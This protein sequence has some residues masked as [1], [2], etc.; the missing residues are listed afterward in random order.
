MSC[1]PVLPTRLNP[2]PVGA[3]V[4]DRLGA[5]ENAK[6]APSRRS[7]R[8]RGRRNGSQTAHGV[9][10][11]RRAAFPGC[12]FGGLSSPPDQLGAGK[13]PEPAGRKACPTG[14]R[15]MERRCNNGGAAP[16][17]NPR[18][19]RASR[20]EGEAESQVGA[21]F[22]ASEEAGGL[23]SFRPVAPMACASLCVYGHV[24]LGRFAAA[25]EKRA[26]AR[27]NGA[28]G[29]VFRGW[30]WGLLAPGGLPFPKLPPANGTW[31]GH[32]AS[33]PHA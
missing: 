26:E 31:L 24:G 9:Q 13:P 8:N 33:V 29:R 23:G 28:A 6:P 20:G 25:A 16:L 11:P 7:G 27:R 2:R 14:R 5:S 3:P 4:W 32:A 17:P 30:F 12:R 19:A 21:Y 18:P 22:N 1:S 15:F 10:E